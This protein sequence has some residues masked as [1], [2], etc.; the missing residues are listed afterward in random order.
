MSWAVG[1]TS[2]GTWQVGTTSIPFPTFAVLTATA[3]RH[4]Q[5]CTVEVVGA[6]STFWIVW[7]PTN[8][9]TDPL[10]INLAV[11]STN[12]DPSGNG[13][14][15]V[16]ANRGAVRYGQNGY[17]F[18]KQAEFSSALLV[19]L[20]TEGGKDYVLLVAPL[21]APEEGVNAIP[22]LAGGDQLIWWNV[23]PSGAVTVNSDRSFVA[24]ATVS[25]FSVEAHIDGF[26]YT[27]TATQT[28][29]AAPARS[30]IGVVANPIEYVVSSVS[31]PSFFAS[32]TSAPK[33][34]T[35]CDGTVLANHTGIHYA[36]IP[37]HNPHSATA[38]KTGTDG[39]TDASGYVTITNI[40]YP[41]NEPVTVIMRWIEGGMDRYVVLYTQ[42][43]A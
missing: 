41:P 24:D 32:W 29:N 4:G 1:T 19:P 9:A 37:G 2:G 15:V 3:Y 17:M 6:T 43:V 11:V 33:P 30:I 18:L 26:G 25:S 10:A 34:V 31:A 21:A 14:V 13:T 7:S 8:N 35:A 36:V 40:N 28:I 39:T 16:T 20:L 42:L 27:N 23:L 12:L 5:N 22:D 38:L